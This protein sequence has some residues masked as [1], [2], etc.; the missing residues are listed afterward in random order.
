MEPY[1][2]HY[3]RRSRPADNPIDPNFHLM[4]DELQRME[5]RLSDKIEG[6]CSGL[7]YRVVDAEQKVEEWFVSLEMARTEAETG[8]ADL[9][10]QFERLKLE[11]NWLNRFM[12]HE[13]M[14]NP[15]TKPDIF[16]TVE[17][18]SPDPP[19]DAEVVDPE[20]H[21]VASHPQDR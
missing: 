10:K 11:V 9:R 7:E 5:S 3:N 18:S 15:H 4:L 19:L 21:R 6:R 17:S 8:C 12:E 13:N 2:H 1:P 14:T 20:G 16:T